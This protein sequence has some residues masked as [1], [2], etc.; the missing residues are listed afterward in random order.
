MPF[1]SFVSHLNIIFHRESKST[2]LR[3]RVRD[4]DS[5]V[6]PGMYDNFLVALIQPYMKVVAESRTL[7]TLTNIDYNS[8]LHTAHTF[9]T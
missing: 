2:G 8:I 1:G 5:D 3:K 6:P 4:M 9:V 7:I